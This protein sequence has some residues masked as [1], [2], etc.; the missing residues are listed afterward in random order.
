MRTAAGSAMPGRRASC[1]AARTSR[2]HRE[3]RAWR[4]RFRAAP[5]SAPAT[6]TRLRFPPGRP[7]TAGGRA[8]PRRSARGLRACRRSRRIGALRRSAVPWPPSRIRRRARARGRRAPAR[9]RGRGPA[10]ALRC[11]R[12]PAPPGPRSFGSVKRRPGVQARTGSRRSPRS[13]PRAPAAMPTP[14]R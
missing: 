1:R 3:H 6:G 2:A 12:L 7:P 9:R 11:G 10:A 4:T 13:A 8:T 5:A 14:R